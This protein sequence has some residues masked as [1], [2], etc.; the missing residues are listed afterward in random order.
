MTAKK[1]LTTVSGSAWI[2]A[3]TPRFANIRDGIDEPA[4]PSTAYKLVAAGVAALGII[5]LL[6]GVPVAAYG[7]YVSAGL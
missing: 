5:A 7:A 2:A 4:T 6:W 3:D 1:Y